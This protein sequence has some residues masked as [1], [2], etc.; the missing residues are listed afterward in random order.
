MNSLLK[1]G[2]DYLLEDQAQEAFQQADKIIKKVNRPVKKYIIIAI[3]IAIIVV[4]F[5]LFSTIFAL[6]NSN[7][8]KIFSNI[9]VLGI[10]ISNLTKDEA[11]EKLSNA[12][13]QRLT[14]DLIFEHNDKMFSMLPAEIQCGYNIDETI[15]NAYNIGRTG[16]LFQKNFEILNCLVSKTTLNPTLN[17]S[18]DSLS[19]IVTQ[20]N[21]KIPDGLKQPSVVYKDTSIDVIAGKDGYTVVKDKLKE[22]ISSKLL[23]TNYTTEPIKIPIEMK[24]CNP[25]DM[26]KIYKEVYK[27]PVNASYT[28]EP[29]K[30][31]ASSEGLDFAIS[32]DE[33]KALITGDKESYNIPLKRLY[34]T[35]TTDQIGIEAFPDKLASYSTNFST[36]GYNRSNNIIQATKNVNGTVLMPGDVFSFNNVVGQR[37]IASGFLSAGAYSGG[38][39]VNDVGGGICQVSS[40]IYNAA[41]RANLEI[42]DRSNHQFLVGYV[43]IGTDATV[44]WGAPDFK[45][46]NNRNYP[47]KI[48]ATTS[49]KN[50][51]V[52]IYGL[53]QDDDY[54]IQIY[55][56]QTSTVRFSTTYTV[57]KSLA[58]GASKVI[59]SGSNGARS[60][61]YK[62]YKRN[63]VEV[64]RELISND[65]YYPHNQVIARNP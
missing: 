53:K 9:S 62:I 22:E 39:V 33:A 65:Y 34:P 32:L 28:A 63:G 61:T 56:Y 59:Q 8:T 35:V 60:A 46:K 36:S 6:V 41:L 24:K 18:D 4:F 30:I 50:V 58:K 27:E 23:E 25:I 48:V 19:I 17:L 15:D 49:N 3:I 10:D 37:T 5:T 64:T 47:I 12:L 51:Y 42:V 38:Q 43:P 54:E 45:F 2:K 13:N 14:T 21:Q 16:N 11:R 40:T 31:T 52:D 1:D 29:L 20:I 57:D 55:S 26:D 7:S 44:S